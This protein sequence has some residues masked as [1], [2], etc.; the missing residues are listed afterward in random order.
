[1]DLL[2]L[3]FG[4]VN[5]P[6]FATFL[7]GMF[8]KRATGHGAFWGLVSG[9]SA[10]ALVHGLTLAEGKGGWI[11][12]GPLFEFNSSMGQAFYIA[13]A[14]W[15]V[16][17]LTT[18]IVSLMTKPKTDQQMEGLVYS[19]TQRPIIGGIAWFLR[20]APLAIGV[21]VV[22]ALLNIIFW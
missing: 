16:C 5:A 12:V 22:T 15:S 19:L 3:V 10:A 21:L 11:P 6:L 9:T 8:W 20:P 13:I 18:I 4:F 2:Q 1:M 7:L 17:F 14:S